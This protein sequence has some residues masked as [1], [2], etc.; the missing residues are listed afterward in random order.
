MDFG[1]PKVSQWLLI[2]IQ[3]ITT[4]LVLS[5]EKN[6]S[7]TVAHELLNFWPKSQAEG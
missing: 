4:G 1:R 6:M 5:I 2:V 7:W 3:L